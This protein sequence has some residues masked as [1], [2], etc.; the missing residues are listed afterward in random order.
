MNSKTEN[1]IRYGV[2]G[3][4]P[5]IACA[6]LIGTG[7]TPQRLISDLNQLLRDPTL[8]GVTLFHSRITEFVEC[9]E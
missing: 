5:R 9:F 7:T 3:R 2:A 4:G 6:A 8:L 1:A